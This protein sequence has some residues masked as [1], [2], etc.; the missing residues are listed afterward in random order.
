VGAVGRREAREDS[1]VTTTE[2]RMICLCGRP[3]QQGIDAAYGWKWAGCGR[4]GVHASAWTD[5]ELCEQWRR[6]VRSRI[7]VD[8]WVGSV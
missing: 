4:C 8:G 7:W 2:Q 5:D 6:A 3:P 1:S